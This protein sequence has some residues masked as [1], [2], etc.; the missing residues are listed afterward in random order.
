MSWFGM[1]I[2]IDF[3]PGGLIWGLD[4]G[5]GTTVGGGRDAGE[6]L[7]GRQEVVNCWREH[8]DGSWGGSRDAGRQ[9]VVVNEYSASRRTDVGGRAPSLPPFFPRRPFGDCRM[10]KLPCISSSSP[11]V[12][13]LLSLSVQPSP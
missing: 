4:G 12:L 13:L 7:C 6:L 1:R 5:P 2:G 11:V 8:T 3:V 10:R 9:L